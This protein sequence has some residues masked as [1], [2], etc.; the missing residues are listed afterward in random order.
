MCTLDIFAVLIIL[1][2]VLI[3][4]AKEKQQTKKETLIRDYR[5]HAY[6]IYSSDSSKCTDCTEL[7]ERFLLT[8]GRKDRYVAHMWDVSKSRTKLD[9]FSREHK[10]AVRSLPTLIIERDGI[11]T[12]YEGTAI[13]RLVIKDLI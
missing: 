12:V 4:M 6:L 2:L 8:V 1:L 5:P 9:E 10:I 3:I 13:I 7:A 11:L